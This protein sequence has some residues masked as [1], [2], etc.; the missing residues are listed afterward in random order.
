MSIKNIQGTLKNQQE[1]G[2][3]SNTKVDES[4]EL[5]IFRMGIPN[6]NRYMDIC[7]D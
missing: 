4:C 5:D 1:K 7:R 3:I 2:K 6:A